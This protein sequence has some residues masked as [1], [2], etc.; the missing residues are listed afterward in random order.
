MREPATTSEAPGSGSGRME[1]AIDGDEEGNGGRKRERERKRGEESGERRASREHL[2]ET[3]LISPSVAFAWASRPPTETNTNERRRIPA[4]LSHRPMKT[5]RSDR[6]LR[7]P[8]GQ[9]TGIRLVFWP[10]C[11]PPAFHPKVKRRNSQP[12]RIPT[13]PV[14]T[15]KW[16]TVEAPPS[17]TLIF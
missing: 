12:P 6:F 11:D 13:L 1:K 4:N 8:S 3:S 2:S 5:D 14:G 9:L 16:E 17:G 15:W 10:F 7:S